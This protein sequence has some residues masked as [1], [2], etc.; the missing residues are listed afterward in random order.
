MT[1][2]WVMTEHGEVSIAT[3]TKDD[4]YKRAV[5][6][7]IYANLHDY[8]GDI[9]WILNLRTKEGF[10]A[11]D[12]LNDLHN[13]H[14]YESDNVLLFAQ[15]GT[16]C[17]IPPADT[18]EQGKSYIHSQANVLNI[19]GFANIFFNRIM[20]KS[21]GNYTIFLFNNNY[22]KEWIK[23]NTGENKIIRHSNM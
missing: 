12:V 6:S 2:E 8:D 14:H 23:N 17:P 11:K 13:N 18:I 21:Y 9:N 4:P 15:A 3:Y 19:T 1:S 20:G 10:T 16:I 5:V 7:D 22:A